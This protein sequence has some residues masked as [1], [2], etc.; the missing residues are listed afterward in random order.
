MRGSEDAGGWPGQRQQL[1]RGANFKPLPD[2]RTRRGAEV[3]LGESDQGLGWDALCSAVDD[4]LGVL[5]AR[6]SD[7][8]AIS[9]T[10]Y[11]GTERHRTYCTSDADINDMWR[12]LKGLADGSVDPPT[13]MPLKASG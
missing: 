3:R 4:G 1:G 5:M 7:G 9:V 13:P 11:Q 12:A 2:F 10:V 6:T 8:G